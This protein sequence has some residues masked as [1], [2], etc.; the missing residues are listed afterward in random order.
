VANNMKL[1]F[2][3]CQVPRVRMHSLQY[4][5]MVQFLMKHRDS[6]T[7]SVYFNANFNIVFLR[8]LASASVGE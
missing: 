2:H 3:L 8:Q 5:F 6:A 4:H 1:T 7:L